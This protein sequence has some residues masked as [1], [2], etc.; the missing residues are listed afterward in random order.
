MVFKSTIS[1]VRIQI[2]YL[3]CKKPVLYLSTSKAQV[4]EK[5][6]K[7]TLFHAS[8]VFQIL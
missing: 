3:L 8:V 4:T 1:C 2:H 6:F 5:A 7:L